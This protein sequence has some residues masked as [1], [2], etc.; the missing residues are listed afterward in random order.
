M[1]AALAILAGG[2]VVYLAV[3]TMRRTT[4]DLRRKWK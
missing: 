3:R 1:S 2:F 4:R